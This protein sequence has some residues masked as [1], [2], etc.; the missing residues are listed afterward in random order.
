MEAHSNC[1]EG[2]CIPSL[3]KISKKLSALV[4]SPLEGPGLALFFPMS[5]EMLTE[6]SQ[7]LPRHTEKTKQNNLAVLHVGVGLFPAV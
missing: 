1:V 6:Q 3:E 4:K 2:S 5:E 7:T